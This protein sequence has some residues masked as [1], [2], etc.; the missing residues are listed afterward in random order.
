MLV[1]AAGLSFEPQLLAGAAVEAGELLFQ[2]DGKAFFVHIGKGQHLIRLVI[3]NDGGDQTLFIKFQ[4]VDIHIIT[5]LK[6]RY[7]EVSVSDPGSG[8]VRSGK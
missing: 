7:P 8:P 3:Y 5:S 2:R 6:Y 4:T 1:V